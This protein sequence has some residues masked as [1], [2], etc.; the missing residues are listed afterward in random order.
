MD[1][2]TLLISAGFT[3]PTVGGGIAWVWKE[4]KASRRESERR[5]ALVEADLD[6][7]R[8]RE[9][10]GVRYLS[11]HLTVIELLWQDIRAL[12]GGRQTPAQKRA[13]KLLD[14]LKLDL[15]EDDPE[16]TALAL[17]IDE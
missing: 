6:K 17:R 8:K 7:C 15:P 3:L 13:K 5:F 14:G 4:I 2:S 1:V 11:V 9:V 12:T 16:L 10:R